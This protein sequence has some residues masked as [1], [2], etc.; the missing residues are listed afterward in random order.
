[1][2]G[3]QFDRISVSNGLPSLSQC[4]L[5][6]ILATQDGQLQPL[7]QVDLSRRTGL[8]P[9]NITG[10]CERLSRDG[11][12]RRAPKAGDRRVNEVRLLPASVTALEAA[13]RADDGLTA[14]M[15][16][17]LSAAEKKKLYTLLDKVLIRLKEPELRDAPP[18][19]PLAV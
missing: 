13:A 4:R 11:W 6:G 8:S 15:M 7:S 5:L 12:I 2:Y 17:G 16:A 19:Q 1:M 3:V 14:K 9:M 18:S 10:L